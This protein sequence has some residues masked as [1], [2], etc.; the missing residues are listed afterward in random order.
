MLAP[1]TIALFFTVALLAVT[2]YFLLGSVPLLTLQHDN[3]VDSRFIRS[4][5]ITYFRIAFGVAIA[6]ATSYAIAGRWGFATGAAA[7]AILTWVLRKKFITQ[8]DHMAGQ[9]QAQ[10]EEAIPAFQKLHKSAI[11][12]NTTQ[13]LTILCSLGFF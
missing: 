10:N 8:M 3:P 12:I 6:T 4:F 1:Q 11:A 13:L 9:I 2:A 5:Y 7:I